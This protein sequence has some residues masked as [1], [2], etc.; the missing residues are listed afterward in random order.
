[1]ASNQKTTWTKPRHKVFRN[2]LAAILGPYTRLKFGVKPEKFKEQ[3]IASI[4]SL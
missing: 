3:G 4:S 1:M 2:I